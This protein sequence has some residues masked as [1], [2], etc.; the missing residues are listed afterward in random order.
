MGR[1]VVCCILWQ[2]TMVHGVL[3]TRHAQTLHMCRT[4]THT[5]THT[6]SLKHTHNLIHSLS[7][8]SRRHD[9]NLN[10]CSLGADKTHQ[11][12]LLV[13]DGKREGGAPSSE[14]RDSQRE[15]IG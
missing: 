3:L 8:V 14:R 5:H 13:T 7:D 2:L 10:S 11:E 6:H 4:H 1:C 15:R 9:L 12:K